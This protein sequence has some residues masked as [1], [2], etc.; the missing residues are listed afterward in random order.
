MDRKIKI[1]TFGV[2]PM[3]C[4]VVRFAVERG[5]EPVACIGRSR[6]LGEDIG[7][8]AG[9]GPI[10][11]AVEPNTDVDATLKRVKPDVVCDTGAGWPDVMDNI[12]VAVEN[13]CD[14]IV[15]AEQLF[16]LWSEEPEMAL[17]LDRLAKEHDVSVLGLGM[18]D[19]NWVGQCCVMGANS[20]RIDAIEGE[21]VMVL[22]FT[23]PSDWNVVGLNMTAEEFEAHHAQDAYSDNPFTGSLYAIAERMGLHVTQ[24]V[25]AKIKPIFAEE[26]Y[27]SQFIDKD[28]AEK[29]FGGVIKKGR[30]IGCDKTTTL[31]T[32]EGIDLS[33]TQHYRFLTP[34]VVGYNRW[35]FT[36]EPSWDVYVEDGRYDIG[37]VSDVVNRIPDVM[38][39]PA[40][41]LTC[42]Q[43]PTPVFH[44][45]D[46]SQYVNR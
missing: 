13:D 44:V 12:R 8:L 17:E 38:N 2:G 20:Q 6:H 7:E 41:Y 21:N 10:G 15:L 9:I 39:A 45:G 14:V 24:K 32:R 16:H 31:K 30:V 37:T 43:L 29:A 28:T 42:N 3:G 19:V 18:Q 27:V 26:D 25:N 5:C 36:G 4:N 11:V 46:L 23:G 22:D 35:K 33:G 34:G 40:G 1:V